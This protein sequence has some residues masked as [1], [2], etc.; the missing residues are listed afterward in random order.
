MKDALYSGYVRQVRAH[1]EIIVILANYSHL[2][3][4]Y[5]IPYLL[6]YRGEALRLPSVIYAKVNSL[7][8]MLG[9]TTLARI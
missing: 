3:L 7:Q 9:F 4:I 6:R 2:V 8:S 1:Q 5:N